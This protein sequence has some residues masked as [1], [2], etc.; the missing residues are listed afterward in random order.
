MATMLFR[1]NQ[2][3]KLVED[4]VNRLPEPLFVSDKKT[5]L[6]PAMGK[7]DFLVAIAKRLRKYGHSKDNILSRLFGFETN[8]LYVNTFLNKT[9]LK[10]ARVSV[11]TYQEVLDLNLSTEPNMPDNFDCVVSNPPFQISSDGNG[12]NNKLWPLFVQKATEITAPGGYVAFVTPTTW[13]APKNK[14][15]EVFDK[16]HLEWVDL[17]AGKHFNVGSTFSSWILHLVEQKGLTNINGKE[18]DLSNMP[19]ITSAETLPIHQKVVFDYV[20]ERLN[21]EADETANVILTKKRPEFVSRVKTDTHIYEC[22]HTNHQSLWSSRKPKDFDKLKVVFTTSGHVRA[23]LDE[24]KMGVS[25]TSRYILV[26]S[27]EEGKVVVQLLNSKLYQFI[28]ETAKWG[29]FVNV[30]VIKMLPKL[31][32]MCLWPDAELYNH[33]NLTKE[34]IK[35]IKE[36]IK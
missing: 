26:D 12:N 18:Y 25:N 23:F 6:D 8:Q 11:K 30:N 3:P 21:I 13:Q 5:F 15:R 10:G 34:E 17:T 4:F 7:G 19:Y 33:F 28:M 16:F 9:P 22:Y 27:I 29:G 31:D 2:P 14:A 32:L 24:G 36:I 35:L 20:G 1:M